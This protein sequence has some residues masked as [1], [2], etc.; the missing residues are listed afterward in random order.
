MDTEWRLTPVRIVPV[1]WMWIT[2]GMDSVAI[3]LW[4][5]NLKSGDMVRG[6]L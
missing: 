3:I 4:G 2:M 5:M 6:V 1:S